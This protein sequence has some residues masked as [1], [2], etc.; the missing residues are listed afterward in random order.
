MKRIV[1][2]VGVR[3]AGKTTL[4]ASLNRHANIE[5]LKPTTNRPKRGG[6]EEY[7]FIDEFPHGNS[8]AWKLEVGDYSYGVTKERVKLIPDGYCGVT[9]FDPGNIGILENYR[10]QWRE[11]EIV[12]VGL[13]T[14][15]TL[16]HQHDRVQS[17]KNRMM[18]QEVFD[19]QRNEVLN[20]DIV[21]R[22]DANAVKEAT[23]AICEILASRGGIV[24][25]NWLEPLIKA[26]ALLDGARKSQIEPASYDLRLGDEVWC[27]GI[28]HPLTVE[29][30]FFKIPP[31]SYA[32][33]KAEETARIPCFMVGRFDITVSLFF[34]G[35][36]LSNGPQVD[37]GYHGA[38]F[39][40]L[41]NGR[42]VHADLKMGEHF[43]TLE[44]CT[45][46][47]R[48]EGYAGQYQ[49]KGSLNEFLAAETGGGPGGNIVGRIEDLEGESKG[50]LVKV[51]LVLAAL[52]AVPSGIQI[53]MINNFSDRATETLEQAKSKVDRDIEMILKDLP[54]KTE[55]ARES[56]LDEAV[57][58]DRL[59]A[60]I[61]AM[62]K[63]VGLLGK[64]LKRLEENEARNSDDAE[65]VLP[66]TDPNR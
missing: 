49:D 22:G 26:G 65:A 55:E 47:S 30:P 58:I 45:L 20:S 38:L 39:C 61:D 51:F 18:T 56:L 6:T 10:R 43:A 34:K 2:L 36:L 50:R 48:I 27:Q 63:R 15:E 46:G 37:P 29:N 9:V 16:S 3:G 17:D 11:G 21:L 8:M 1:A 7:E 64:D 24:G 33:V 44:F 13:D 23:I 12:T 59:R 52:I 35:V 4:L 42:D 66:S 32:I 40:T 41:F 53:W 25:R 14:I 62:H 54:Q 28:R 57:R 19:A 5:V 60:E 31:Y